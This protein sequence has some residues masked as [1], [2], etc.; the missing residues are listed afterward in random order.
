MA[1]TGIWLTTLQ[2]LNENE[3]CAIQKT[4]LFVRSKKSLYHEMLIHNL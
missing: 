1:I 2:N 4:F 3:I